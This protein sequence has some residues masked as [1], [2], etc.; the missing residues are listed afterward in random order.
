VEESLQE[1]ATFGVD[2]S[3]IQGE[4]DWATVAASGVTLAMNHLR[5]I[6]TS[7]GT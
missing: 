1:V 7:I 2:V 5:M 6:G 4:I 3:D